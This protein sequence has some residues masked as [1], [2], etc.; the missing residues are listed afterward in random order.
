LRTLDGRTAWVTGA[1]GGIGAPLVRLLS[2]RGADVN[3]IDRVACAAPGIVVDLADEG[4]LAELCAILRDGPPDVFV[5]LAGVMAFG[6]LAA[7][8][9]AQI[10]A[11]YRL[12][13][14]VPALLAQAAAQGMQRRGSGRIV[15]VGSMLGA[16]P[17]P[18]FAAYSSSKAGLA[19]LS[20]ALRR[21]LAGS[22]VEVTHVAPRAAKTPFNTGPVERFLA[23]T[24]MKA[25]AS[26]DVARR[27]VAA[28]CRSER[29][30]G[31]GAMER[32]FAA[33]NALAPR[34]IDRGLAGQMAAARRAFPE[35]DTR[36]ED[37]P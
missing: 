13:L 18:W 22:G 15:T 21:E 6:P 8:D 28:I 30:V 35:F 31:I 26:D 2:A 19:A 5:S 1:A 33:L 32:V 23:A 16:I 7:A 36:R 37:T 17:F 24:G 9:P 10:V 34:L 25:D 20:Q 3:A 4:A 11:C 27:I 14:V 29:D 12:N